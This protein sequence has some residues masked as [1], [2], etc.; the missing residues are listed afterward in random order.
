MKKSLI[1]LFFSA[2][3]SVAAFAQSVQEGVGHLNAERY[4]SARTTFEKLLAAN[5]NNIDAMYWLGQTYLAQDNFPA[6]RSLYEKGLSSNGNA[7][8]LMVGMGQVELEENRTAEARQHFEQAISL[9]RGKKGD[10]PNVLNAIGRANVQA[11]NGDAAYAIAKL[12]AAS[13]AAPTNSDIYINLG[14]AYRLAHDGGQAVANYT[15]AINGSPAL[16]YYQ[17]ARIYETQKNMSIVTEN[18]DKA[19][20]A[21]PRFGPAFLRAYVVELFYNKN[22]A[23]ADQWAQKYV[24]VAD[25]SIQNEV[26]RAQSLYLQKKYDE[27]ISI[28]NRILAQKEERPGP[29]V[30]R[31]MAYSYL[32]KGDTTTARQYVDQLFKNAKPA[33]IVRPDYTLMATIY[34][35]ESPGQVVSI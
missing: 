6:A 34:S 30:Y 27:A 23:A 29:G 1:V 32:E 20:A 19:I 14:N 31:M 2:L 12:T 16:A 26:F 28:G 4:A 9:S 18:L 25:P 35:K 5:P 13:Q 8:L 11:K 7:P 33:D 22:F 15:K 17:M 21:D 3:F 24:A 10:D